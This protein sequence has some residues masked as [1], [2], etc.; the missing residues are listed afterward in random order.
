MYEHQLDDNIF[1]YMRKWKCHHMY[2]EYSKYVLGVEHLCAGQRTVDRGRLSPS[3]MW[4][5]EGMGSCT[6][7]AT[8]DQPRTDIFYYIIA[9]LKHST[10]ISFLNFFLMHDFY[11]FLV[12]IV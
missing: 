1:L 8:P 6:P 9:G 5:G 10:N 11:L 3:T 12:F 7:R 2:L 4:V